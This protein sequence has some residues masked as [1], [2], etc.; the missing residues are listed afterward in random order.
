MKQIKN[1]FG[2]SMIEMLGVLAIIGVLSVGGIAG[3]SKAMEQFKIN[4][5]IDQVSQIVVNTQTLYAQQKDYNGLHADV[6]ISMGIIPDNLGTLDNSSNFSQFKKRFDN[7]PWSNTYMELE[8]VGSRKLFMISLYGSLP[9][10]VCTTLASQNWG[11]SSTGLVSVTVNGPGASPQWDGGIG[12]NGGCHAQYNSDYTQCSS[13]TD[14]DASVVCTKDHSIPMSP[15][16][17]SQICQQCDLYYGCGISLLF[18]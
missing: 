6:A 16:L 13:C 3:Y 15:S 2:R 11:T 1:E 10:K 7:L 4:K 8:G 17:A 5:F 9:E 14:N 12:T 18:Q